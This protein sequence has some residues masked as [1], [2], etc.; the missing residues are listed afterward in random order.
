MKEFCLMFR[1]LVLAAATLSFSLPAVAFEPPPEGSSL[2][3]AFEGE[4]YSPYAA[5]NFPSLPLW[6]DTHLHTSTSFDAG[7]FGNRLDARAAYRFAKGEEVTATT[8][9]KARL[10]RP[11]DFLVVADHSDNMGLF[12]LIFAG[13]RSITS[14]PEGKRIYE[15]IQAGGDKA[16]QASLELIDSFSKGEKISDALNVVPGTKIFRSVWD[17]QIAAAEEANEP[18]RLSLIH[19]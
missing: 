10:S 19:I 17:R 16:V 13:D 11:L 15:L 7:A 12:D 14:D 3:K 4:S 18:G 1:P 2:N 5:R 9:M 8:G 6:G